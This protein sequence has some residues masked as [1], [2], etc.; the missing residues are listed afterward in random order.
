MTPQ[1]R[2]NDALVGLRCEL[3]KQEL[4][5]E[6]TDPGPYASESTPAHHRACKRCSRL[7]N[8]IQALESLAKVYE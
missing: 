1:Q 3:V 5:R 7:D 8:A 6:R 2:I 4:E